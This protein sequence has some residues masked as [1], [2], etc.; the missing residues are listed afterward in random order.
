V[1]AVV[2]EDYRGGNGGGVGVTEVVAEV[3]NDITE[4]VALVV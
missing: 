4:M 3:V 2:V 1:V